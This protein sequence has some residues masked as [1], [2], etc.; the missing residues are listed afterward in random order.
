MRSETEALLV[1]L[2]GLILA[3]LAITGQSELLELLQLL[4][5]YVALF[6]PIVV[7]ASEYIGN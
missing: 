7:I 3:E 5:V 1:L 4:S 6:Y 2:L